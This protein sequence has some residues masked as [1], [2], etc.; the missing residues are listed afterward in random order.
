MCLRR[1]RMPGWIFRIIK[2][3]KLVQFTIIFPVCQSHCVSTETLDWK[4]F[5]WQQS[6][7]CRKSKGDSPACDKDTKIKFGKSINKLKITINTCQI[8]SGLSDCFQTLN[9]SYITQVWPSKLCINTQ[10]WHMSS[11]RQFLD[12]AIAKKNIEV[13]N[14]LAVCSI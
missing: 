10:L 13:K 2:P 8:V 9:F 5:L 3:M 12:A 7:V 4:A 1:K 14:K 6:T 11:R